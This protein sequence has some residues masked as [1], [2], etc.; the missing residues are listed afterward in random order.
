MNSIDQ[1][2][3]GAG[4]RQGYYINYSKLISLMFVIVLSIPACTP[5]NRAQPPTIVAPILAGTVVATQSV[6]EGNLVIRGDDPCSLLTKPQVEAAFA[7]SVTKGTLSRASFGRECEFRLGMEATEFSI[8]YY[9]GQA[10]KN[11][12]AVLI[13]AARQSCEEL[14]NAMLDV[15][16]APLIEK[17]PS[18][19]PFL[20]ELSLEKLYY[21]YI[22]VLGGCMYVHSGGR[23]EIGRN[24]I[25]TETIFLNWSSSVAVL[26]KDRVIELS[27][28]EPIPDE[29][30]QA[31][32]R[33]TDMDSYND[34]AE[35]YQ[36]DVLSGYTEIIIALLKQ[37]AG[38]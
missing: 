9:E 27:Y 36:R 19:D 37:A 30:K 32:S 15:A 18:A 24:V 29:V 4:M 5:S 6:P 34:L 28:T 35:T 7:H 16:V 38:Q 20:L 26:N 31:L 33:G 14:L 13:T 1:L 10:A 25:A 2:L 23:D 22:G 11:Y 12:F 3:R 17:Y 21:D 8:T